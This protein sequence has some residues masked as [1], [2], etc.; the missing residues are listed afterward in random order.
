VAYCVKI[1]LRFLS[2]TL[3]YLTLSSVLFAQVEPDIAS[4]KSDTMSASPSAVREATRALIREDAAKSLVSRE[5]KPPELAGETS[6][7]VV[8][9]APV[10][11][12]VPKLLALPAGREPAIDK[13]FRTGTIIQH[14]GKKVTSRLW[15]S[16]VS[17]IRLSFSW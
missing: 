11:V 6:P 3:G 4:R 5:P 15:L 8:V 7:D 16:G 12:T 17:G 10:V 1:D 13:F 2:S 14:V 9:L